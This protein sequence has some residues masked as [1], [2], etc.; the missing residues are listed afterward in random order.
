MQTRIPIP[1]REVARV[2]LVVACMVGLVAAIFVF[3]F[4]LLAA[5][6]GVIGGV[7]LV[8]WIECWQRRG[9]L[10]HGVAT[11]L[12]ALTF[13][14][15]MGG[16]VYVAWRLIAGQARRLAEQAPTITKNFVEAAQ[17]LAGR[18]PG[19]GF[20]LQ[21]LDMGAALQRAGK[22]LVGALH[23]GVEGLAG[24]VVI[25]MI[26]IFTASNAEAYL[27]GA[28]TLLPPAARLRATALAWGCASVIRRWFTG[29]ILVLSI[30]GTMTAVALGA[31]GIDY[32]LVLALLTAL[33]DFIPFFG[34]FLTGALAVGVTLGTQ[35]DKA[36]WVL[37]IYVAIQ[38]VESDVV[39]P[40][41]MKGRIQLP[42]AHLLVFVLMMGMAFGILGV[43]AAPPIFGILHHL[44]G[45]V[46]VPWIEG[47][48]ARGE[49]ACAA[50]GERTE[51]V[52]RKP[53]HKLKPKEAS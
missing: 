35:P 11:G 8:P 28:L 31:M 52:R 50:G 26:A 29:Q 32:W 47:R 44:Y 14:G 27:R 45:E 46:Y 25:I 41:V 24:V 43:F 7:L 3:R 17:D 2:V 37:L 6:V 39:V 33:L 34:A 10:P 15:A 30:T 4:L 9:R 5:L 38:Q 20:D 40:L 48:E 49:G 42:E 53:D 36:G 51:F 22:A 19:G 21:R 1:S 23:I 13:L 16:V 18:L 12:V